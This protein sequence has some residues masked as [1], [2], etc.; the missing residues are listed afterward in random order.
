MVRA[1]RLVNAKRAEDALSG[2]GAR[3]QGGRWNSRGT[4]VVYA[5][6][7]L[8]LAA[9][10]MLVHLDAALVL[11]AYVVFE[12]EFDEA[13]VREVD[14]YLLVVDWREPLAPA[15]LPRTGD[16]WVASESSAVLRVPS[17]VIPSESNYLI[18]PRHLDFASIH[19]AGPTPFQF[20]RRPARG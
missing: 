7:S 8:S 2:E 19:V 12:L 1:Y 14:R 20:D 9:L 5:S 13:L 17:A 18:N 11:A 15:E 4:R 16:E 6:T 10:E 3:R